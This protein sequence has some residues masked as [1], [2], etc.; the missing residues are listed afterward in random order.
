MSARL[1]PRLGLILLAV[2]GLSVFVATQPSPDDDLAVQG[3]ERPDQASAADGGDASRSRPARTADARPAEAPRPDRANRAGTTAA[4]A[5]SMPTPAQASELASWAGAWA[6]RASAPWVAPSSDARWSWA[7]QQ[8][9][10]PPPPPPQEAAAPTAPP[11]PYAWVGRFV[12]EAPRAVIAGPNG[13]WVLRQ[14]EVI[15]GQ[16]RLDAIAERQL[17]VTYLPLSQEQTVALK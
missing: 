14:G 7:P 17:T 4:R 1:N 10:P 5:A 11:F 16:W 13:T 8:P 12:D 3:R 6:R 9:P 15:E 2:L